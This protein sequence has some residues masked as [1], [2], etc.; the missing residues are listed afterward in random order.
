MPTIQVDYKSIHRCLLNLNFKR[1]QENQYKHYVLATAGN[2]A[3]DMFL[4]RYHF[5]QPNDPVV[6]LQLQ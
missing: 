1:M 4:Y 5:Q 3:Q 2:N 6:P